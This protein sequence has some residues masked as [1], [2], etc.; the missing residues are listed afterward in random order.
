LNCNEVA[1]EREL[2]NVSV[3]RGDGESVQAILRPEG[4]RDALYSTLSK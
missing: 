4:D 2:D 1:A 3:I